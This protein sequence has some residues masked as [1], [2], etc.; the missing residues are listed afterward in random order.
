MIEL[1][2]QLE[3]ERSVRMMLEDQVRTA[4]QLWLKFKVGICINTNIFLPFVADPCSGC[5][6]VPREA[7]GNSPAGSDTKPGSTATEPTG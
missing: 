2:Q 7:K 3:K 4:A 1:R 6:V 5:S